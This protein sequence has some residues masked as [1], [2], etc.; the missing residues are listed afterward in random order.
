MSKEINPILVKKLMQSQLKDLQ[1]NHNRLYEKEETDRMLYQT[2]MP[3]G[4][5][6]QWELQLAASRAL[7]INTIDKVKQLIKEA[8]NEVQK[9]AKRLRKQSKTVYV[10]RQNQAYKGWF[11]Q[12]FV[13]NNTTRKPGIRVGPGTQFIGSTK[14]VEY[15]PEGWKSVDKP[16]YKYYYEWT[17]DPGA[18]KTLSHPGWAEKR[19]INFSRWNTNGSLDTSK[20]TMQD[21]RTV[22]YFEMDPRTYFNT[23]VWSG[24]HTPNIERSAYGL[25]HFKKDSTLREDFIKNNNPYENYDA[26]H[27]YVLEQ[28]FPSIDIFFNTDPYTGEETFEF[29]EGAFPYF[30]D[31]AENVPIP[32]NQQWDL[33]IKKIVGYGT[34]EYAKNNLKILEK[35]FDRRDDDQSLYWQYLLTP[36]ENKKKFWDDHGK[37]QIEINN[38]DLSK[39]S[40][41][42]GDQSNYP[43]LPEPKF[44]PQKPVRTYIPS[45]IAAITTK[46]EMYRRNVYERGDLTHRWYQPRPQPG[47]TF[48]P[49][50]D[51]VNPRYW[52]GRKLARTSTPY[53]QAIWAQK[54]AQKRAER[55]ARWNSLFTADII[56]PLSS[57]DT[58]NIMRTYVEDVLPIATQIAISV[59]VG[60]A[61]GPAVGAINTQ[62]TAVSS[63]SNALVTN[64]ELGDTDIGRI[65]ARVGEAVAIANITD[66]AVGDVVQKVIEDE[67]YKI[68][69]REIGK[70]T[71]LDKSILG[72]LTLDV[73]AGTAYQMYQSKDFVD[74]LQDTADKAWRVEAAKQSPFAAVLIAGITEIEK[75]GFPELSDL[76]PMKLFESIS[77]ESMGDEIKRIVG[78][79]RGKDVA[80]LVG[81]G[82]LVS[83]NR[84]SPEDAGMYVMQDIA[85]KNLEKF[86]HDEPVKKTPLSAYDKAQQHN[87]RWQKAMNVSRKLSEGL[88]PT[89][90]DIMVITDSV[91]G[92]LYDSVKKMG[93]PTKVEVSFWDMAINEVGMPNL[94]QYVPSVDITIPSWMQSSKDQAQKSVDIINAGKTEKYF[95]DKFTEG[96]EITKEDIAMLIVSLFPRNVPLVPLRKEPGPPTFNYIDNFGNVNIREPL[97]FPYD[98]PMLKTGVIPKKYTKKEKQYM[99][100]REKEMLAARAVL[101][102]IQRKLEEM[103][104]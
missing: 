38:I 22:S 36:N 82:I 4:E 12:N 88:P 19:G 34:E 66:A 46:P 92:P 53:Q 43:G 13:M 35:Y 15:W 96:T 30:M 80:K 37:R 61:I 8:H 57:A 78:S 83:Q 3:V 44:G 84:M 74:A 29:D 69:K 93:L 55:K 81:V 26:G 68:G 64:T 18:D 63:I 73:T 89:K 6:R 14:K 33:A 5:F 10:S 97:K 65:L 41:G 104:A 23:Y 85:V 27:K 16:G 62:V 95:R 20:W 52:T 47:Y 77:W 58:L 103:N 11:N 94:A 28:C 54:R 60:V 90:D 98:H 76:D 9:Y 101:S 50:L 24:A 79:I 48:V 86:Y 1:E 7:R 31:F 45:N 42:W 75:N 25:S 91:A 39:E 17:V 71:G 87:I 67:L 21:A 102:E 59:T 56:N 40:P 32:N 72:R 49:G 99:M 70:S 51:Y 2:T 100:E